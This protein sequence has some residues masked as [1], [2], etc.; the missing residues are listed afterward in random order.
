M[1]LL[2]KRWIKSLIM[3]WNQ[4]FA[5]VFCNLKSP[6]VSH[7]RAGLIYILWLQVRVSFKGRPLW[8]A[9]LFQG[10][11]VIHTA[12]YFERHINSVV[13]GLGVYDKDSMYQKSKISII[14]DAC[15]NLTQRNIALVTF[16]LTCVLLKFSHIGI[17]SHNILT[18]NVTW[19]SFKED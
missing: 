18:W 12:L 13:Q 6:C 4:I 3:K 15:W 19:L 2:W 14:V 9:G 8:R 11:T 7:S 16:K 1:T 17:L 5:K 10:F